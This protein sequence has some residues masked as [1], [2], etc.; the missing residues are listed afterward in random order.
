MQVILTGDFFQLPP[1]PDLKTRRRKFAFE[2]K[3]WSSV[4]NRS[5][6][7]K[8]VLRQDDEHFVRLLNEIRLG[9]VSAEA[10]R[11]LTF[12]HRELK[13]L[14][15]AFRPIQLYPYR[16]D[17]DFVNN[18]RLAALK[19]HPRRFNTQ[20]WGD[21]RLLQH[22]IAPEILELKIGAPV[23]LIR[24]LDPDLVNGSVG[25][26]ID[27]DFYPIVLFRNGR[28]IKVEPVSW[29]IEWSCEDKTCAV[30]ARLGAD[31][32]QDAGDDP[33]LR[34]AY[35]ALSRATSLNG[36]QVLNFSQAKIMAHPKVTRFYEKLSPESTDSDVHPQNSLE[37][38]NSYIIDA[39][40]QNSP[41]S[42]NAPPQY[43]PESTNAPPQNSLEST[44]Y[45]MPF[46]QD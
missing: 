14:D 37:S 27:F 11:V 21:I 3:T 24:N 22:C 5:F 8:T 35:V 26:V 33:G 43:S 13:S 12:L 41:E 44:S 23:I 10:L 29:T 2:A 9:K 34:Q 25:T 15:R 32:P 7:L 28:E 42:T 19:G 39:A 1:V 18:T 16:S 38:A 30:V 4:V 31:Y 6:V 46:I 20:D 17:V 40:P 36:L 45:N